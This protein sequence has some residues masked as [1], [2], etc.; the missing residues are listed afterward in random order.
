M[1]TKYFVAAMAAAFSIAGAAYASPA[2]I[3]ASGHYEWRQIPSYGPRTPLAAPR[4]VWVSDSPQ[5][6]NCACDMMRM[7]AADCMKAMTGMAPPS[8][9]VS[10]G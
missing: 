1:K 10:A 5:T 7:S 9:A 3:D 6:A 4:R 8:S 2:P